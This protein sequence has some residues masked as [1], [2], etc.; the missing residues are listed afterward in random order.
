MH[1]QGLRFNSEAASAFVAAIK[2]AGGPGSELKA[3]DVWALL[4]LHSAEGA[5]RKAVEAAARAKLQAGQLPLDLL[6]QSVRVCRGARRPR[7]RAEL[8]LIRFETPVDLSRP[9]RFRAIALCS[10]ACGD[11]HAVAPGD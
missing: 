1:P 8:S 11:A 10:P 2:A 4:L 7:P 5:E 9:T 3:V 6:R